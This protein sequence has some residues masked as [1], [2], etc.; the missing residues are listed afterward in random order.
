MIMISFLWSCNHLSLIHRISIE[1]G[2]FNSMTL[3]NGSSLPS[4][5]IIINDHEGWGGGNIIENN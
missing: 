5:K 3:Y 2:L 4:Y 1:D